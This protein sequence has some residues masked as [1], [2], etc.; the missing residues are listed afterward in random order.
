M[1]HTASLDTFLDILTEAIFA[2]RDDAEVRR[3]LSQGFDLAAEI[4]GMPEAATDAPKP[5]KKAPG[6]PAAP[7]PDEKPKIVLPK[8]VRILPDAPDSEPDAEIAIP[9]K[10]TLKV[11]TF[12][13]LS[14]LRRAGKAGTAQ[15]IAASGGKLDAAD[16]INAAGANK[17]SDEVWQLIA[18]ALDQIEAVEERP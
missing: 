10:E 12:R 17:V 7:K 1:K 8:N 9:Q 2:K 3:L 15:I 14:E 18:A 16:I 11:A 4:A 6:R 5:E 13:R